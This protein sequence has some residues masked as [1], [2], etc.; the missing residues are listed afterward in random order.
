MS[1]ILYNGKWKGIWDRPKYQEFRN[2]IL[3]TFNELVFDEEP[4]KYYLNGVEITCV[5]NVT[6]LFQERFDEEGIAQRTFE[7]Y[8]DDPD[9]KY[10]QMTVDEII[11]SWHQNS[12]NACNH[13]TERHEFGESCF[14]FMTE[15]YDKILPQFKDRLIL[16][17]NNNGVYGFEALYPKEEA[18]VKFWEDIPMCIVPILA[19]N[20]VYDAGL[21]Y[22]G[23]FDMLFYYDAELDGKDASKSGF[24]I[25]DYKTNKDLYKN[26]NEK[27]LLAPFNELLDM[28]L[29][30][31]KLQLSL[32][33]NCIE[34]ID[35]HVIARS[36]IWLKPNGE[37]EKIK[38]EEYVKKLRNA[39]S[40]MNLAAH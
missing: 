40:K 26:F 9:S 28:P 16:P 10:Y 11:E 5:S 24:Y 34:L 4:H 17:E 18:T 38:L 15:Q 23:T 12:K 39:L 2:K 22:S 20:K 19:E 32:Y 1:R 8:Y 33:Q 29:N 35:M 7:K 36:L 37:Y 31:Y 14:Y 30:I 3:D 27:K 6:H 21:G 25:M 13:G